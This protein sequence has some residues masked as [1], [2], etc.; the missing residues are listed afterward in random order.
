MKHKG[1]CATQDYDDA[2]TDILKC[3]RSGTILPLTEGRGLLLL[4]TIPFRPS[5]ALRQQLRS[6]A[7]DLKISDNVL[8]HVVDLDE[9][10]SGKESVLIM[11]EGKLKRENYERLLHW[12]FGHTNSKVLQ[13]MEL[14]EKSHLNEDCYCC[15]EAKFKRAPFP[16][17]EG[18]FVAVAE[19]YWRP[20]F[21]R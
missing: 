14:I 18:M 10:G 6:Y 4:K 19:P 20:T 7:K 21:V 9:I 12:R 16:K 8:P 15:N 1:L 3:K 11:N 13:A 5:D 17:N 2:G